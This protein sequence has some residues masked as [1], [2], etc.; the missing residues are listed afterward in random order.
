MVNSTPI[1]YHRPPNDD[2]VLHPPLVVLHHVTWQTY[3]ALLADRGEDRSA[4]L[5]DDRDT[6]EIE[7]KLPSK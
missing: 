3:Q 2:G 6:L 5:A 7:I 1:I 4:R